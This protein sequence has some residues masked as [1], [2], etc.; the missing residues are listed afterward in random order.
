MN[1]LL[2][3]LAFKYE[4]NVFKIYNALK[5]KEKISDKE[6]E[7]TI[8][9][10]NENKINFITVLD[11]EY[12]ERIKQVKYV[13]YVLFYKGN[14]DL[15]NKN[16]ICLA[17]EDANKTVFSYINNSLPKIA[18]S[19]VL[20]TNNFKNL[21]QL[22][23]DFYRKINRPI[24]FVLPF[25]HEFQKDYGN[26]NNE[27]YISPYPWNTHA[28]YKRF[29]ERNVLTGLISNKLIIYNCSIDS[30]I[31]NIANVFNNLNKDVCCYPGTNLDDGNNYLIKMG[32][33]LVTHVA[34]I[35]NF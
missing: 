2:V 29:K 3:Y 19:T 25:G 11:K 21:D 17:G 8:N 24:I 32:A 1:N 14:I 30:G 31:L 33:N 10:L 20:V 34:E 28:K 4:G 18:K 13:P 16:T 26:L 22:F 7:N 27:L 23:I 6:I 5:N 15:L 35:V 9:F 12:P